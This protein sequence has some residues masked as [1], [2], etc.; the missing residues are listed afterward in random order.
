MKIDAVITWVDGN[1]PILAAKRSQYGDKKALIREDIGGATRFSN[2]GEIHWCIRSLNKYAPYLNKIYIITD[3]QDPCVESR[4]PVE[5]VD[6][7]Q[8]FKG[9]EEYLPVFNSP[10][11]ETMMWR[12][13]GLS[14]H[15]ILLN[16]DFLL[17]RPTSPSDFFTDDG[18]AICYARKFSTYWAKTLFYLSSLKSGYK[19]VT[20]KHALYQGSDLAGNRRF[21]FY[22]VHTPRAFLKSECEKYYSE[23]PEDIITNIK[24][25]FRDVGQYQIQSLL[26]SLMWEKNMCILRKP[27]KYLLFVQHWKGVKYLSEKF[28]KADNNPDCIFACFN[29]LDNASDEE[30][31]TVT[32][33]V[34][35]KI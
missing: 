12:I 32:D 25:R 28:L 33:W 2:L 21:F 18:K 7:K 3:G 14:E 27:S 6:H 35:S 15:F 17:I 16:D 29:S 20:F 30:R 31:Q 8:V 4:I 5:I 19:R 24:Y 26:Y 9:Y 10:A 11:I 13:P 22:L 34:D 23:H 1:D